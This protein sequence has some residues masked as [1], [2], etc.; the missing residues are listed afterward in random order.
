MATVS[1]LNPESAKTSVA[2]TAPTPSF[3]DEEVRVLLKHGGP[4]GRRAVNED[5]KGYRTVLHPGSV[6]VFDA[7][8]D[9]GEVIIQHRVSLESDG[10]VVTIS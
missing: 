2:I 7:D 1:V 8:S 9:E 5:G 3:S 6:V 4:T 10:L